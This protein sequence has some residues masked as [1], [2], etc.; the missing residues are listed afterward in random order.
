MLKI[1]ELKAGDFIKYKGHSEGY[2]IMQIQFI[3][4]YAQEI[5]T[6]NNE[7]GCG[8]VLIKEINELEKLPYQ[9]QMKLEN[10]QFKEIDNKPEF[11]L[12]DEDTQLINLN[13]V[14]EFTNIDTGEKVLRKVNGIIKVN[15]GKNGNLLEFYEIDIYDY[16]L[17]ETDIMIRE[18]LEIYTQEQIDK[19]GLVSIHT[20][21]YQ[22]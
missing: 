3:D 15:I 5:V 7:Y 1:E 8:G 6:D 18:L 19:H 2:G 20:E 14:I 22:K 9:Y 12:L 16:D 4:H 17:Y 13:D 11:R 21:E 10:K